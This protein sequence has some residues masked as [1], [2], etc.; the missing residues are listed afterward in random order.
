MI[1]WLYG[2]REKQ[3]IELRYI[4]QTANLSQRL[5]SHRQRPNSMF[6]PDDFARWIASTEVE[7]VTLGL[8]HDR[9]LARLRE[10][11]LIHAFSCV[12]HRLF[13]VHG[14]TRNRKAAQFCSLQP[15]G[16]AA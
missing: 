10:R 8:E 6:I 16:I 11:S 13:N 5:S 7:L 12:G 4:G 1:I 15:A 2:L 9:E 3:S 14:V